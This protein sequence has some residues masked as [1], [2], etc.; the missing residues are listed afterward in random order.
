MS[1]SVRDG[2]QEWDLR[3]PLALAEQWA[4]ARWAL[5]LERAPWVWPYGLLSLLL[6]LVYGSVWLT[7]DALLLGGD[8]YLIHYPL[9]FYLRDSIFRGQ[10][11][12]W[13]P[14]TF[15]G[16]PALANPEA[17][18]FYPPNWLTL[19]LP[20]YLAMNWS[21]GLHIMLAG[22][23]AAWC[24]SR[25]GA[26]R[27]GQFLCGIA[28]A[29]GSAMVAR[30]SG[31]HLP[32]LEGNAWL[33]IETGLV[34]TILRPRM[35]V[36]L[37][38][39]TALI[40]LAGRPELPIFLV[41]WLPLWAYLAA[42]SAGHRAVGRALFRTALGA[43]L[44][45]ALAAAQLAPTAALLSVSPRTTGSMGWDFLTSA[46][47]PLWHLLGVITPTAFGA[48]SGY[49]VGDSSEW[50]ERLLYLG[51][52]P[53][54]AALFA[55]GRW[56]WAC[57]GVAVLALM[58]AAGRYVPWYAWV[59]GVLPGYG[60]FRIPSRHLGL[61]ALVLSLAAGLGADRLRGRSA[62]TIAIGCAV[63]V[64]ALSLTLD[65]WLPLA[66]TVF[67]GADR[68][69]S[70][71]A[72]V[73]VSALAA[74]ALQG[75]SL[76]FL[77][78]GLAAILP[79]VWA[80]RAV[81]A[82]AVLELL[83]VLAPYRLSRSDGQNL[84]TSAQLLLGRE[85]AVYL[86]NGG[87]L[88]AN[89]GPVFHVRQPVGY[90]WMYNRDYGVLL[91]GTRSWVAFDVDKPEARPL[92]LLG[93][94]TVIDPS[95]RLVTVREPRSPRVWVARCAWPGSA[96]TVRQ[97]DFP[98]SSCVVREGAARG[99][100]TTPPGPATI[101]AEGT[102]WLAMMA[103]GPGW[104]VTDQPWYPGWDATL[105]GQPVPVETVDGALVGVSLPPGWHEV[106]VSYLPAG[107]QI[108][109]GVSSLAALLLTVVGWRDWRSRRHR[110]A[111]AQT[112]G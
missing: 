60:S 49:W 95:K 19:L 21:L 16:V 7:S 94:D 13:N 111:Q 110:S 37:A 80:G 28:Y 55:H 24:A 36:P 98:W 82:L 15:S 25:M 86:G 41:W 6:A 73:N 9:L 62:A 54:L 105:D 12:L 106:R 26:S 65:L 104:L 61:A 33:P 30:Q 81:L 32:Y 1:A 46:S 43:G 10:L 38:L 97:A 87:A 4:E 107:W 89:L 58:L 57:W 78:V 92:Y 14:Y 8:A 47:Y 45:A 39:V 112:T 64:N 40:V 90:S 52:V 69:A 44:G 79:G 93:Y 5:L 31:G 48:P 76:V 51:T 75:A 20:T 109:L 68:L 59:Q 34:V 3:R 27:D 74:P 96:S 72:S 29:L 50:H 108:G 99:D 103:E 67:G 23:G 35:V 85:R 56:R 2:G 22:A 91:T 66:A 100:A 18:Y 17:A 63:A 11:P 102:G 71:A 84:L 53:L 70:A 42:R 88:L 83:V 101:T 77:L